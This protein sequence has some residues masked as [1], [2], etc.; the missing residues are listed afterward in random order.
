MKVCG[1][2][3]NSFLNQALFLGELEVD[4]LKQKSALIHGSYKLK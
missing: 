2:I 3:N 1:M 4:S